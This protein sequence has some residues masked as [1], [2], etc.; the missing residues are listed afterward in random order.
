M[1]SARWPVYA[2][3]WSLLRCRV[4]STSDRGVNWPL[5]SQAASRALLTT[6]TSH[7][8][9]IHRL[10][11]NVT[12]S[13]LPTTPPLPAPYTHHIYTR[14]YGFDRQDVRT[15]PPAHPPPSAIHIYTDHIHFIMG[16]TVRT[17]PP[18]QP[19]GLKNLLKFPL[20]LL[21]FPWADQNSTGLGPRASC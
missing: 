6:D 21:Y 3:W 18:A 1:F 9:D 10:P 16:L 20:A 15:S 13:S 4:I 7:Y 11:Q 19:M 17:S 12:P 5:T 2:P 8:E 14:H